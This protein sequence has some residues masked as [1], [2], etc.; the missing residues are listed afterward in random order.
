M[1]SLDYASIV[2]PNVTRSTFVRPRCDMSV[3]VL[4]PYHF[5]LPINQLGGAGLWHGVILNELHRKNYWS[6]VRA[7]RGYF[8][9]EVQAEMITK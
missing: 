1:H 2:M 4:Q 6:C 9:V 5:L 8:T 3:S 7:H